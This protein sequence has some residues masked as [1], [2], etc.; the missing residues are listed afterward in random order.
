MAKV[1]ELGKDNVPEEGEGSEYGR[2]W[3][4]EA[5][6]KKRGYA[7]RK[8]DPDSQPWV[9]KEQRQGGK[10]LSLSLSLSLL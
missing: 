3:R 6:R 7:M 1:E 10:Q 4:Q 2:K 9:L 5:R 8:V